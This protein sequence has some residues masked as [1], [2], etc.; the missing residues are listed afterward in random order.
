MGKR[1]TARTEAMKV[2]VTGG[3]G[4]VGK[5]V[6]RQ[7]VARGWSVRSFS[8]SRYDELASLGV[9]QRTGDIADSDAV[10]RAVEGCSCVVHTAA[11]AG[12]WGNAETFHRTNVLGT[13]HV[14][15]ACRHFS[16]RQLV[17]TS[18]PSVVHQGADIEGGDETLPYAT[19]PQSH[20][21]RTKIAAEKMVRAAEDLDTVSLRPHLIWGPGDPH[22][23]PRIRA[24]VR[25]GRIALPG[26]GQKL[27][28][29]TFI[30]NAASAH[31]AAIDTLISNPQSVR[32]RA[33]FITNGQPVE[34]AWIISEILRATGRQARVA[35]IPV[36]LAR[37]A[38]HLLEGAYRTFGIE[39]EPPLTRFVAHQLSSAHWYDLT[40]AQEL[41]GY[42]PEMS[43][44][45]GL[46]ILRKA[47]ASETE[48]KTPGAPRPA[49]PTL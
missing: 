47:W 12:V 40:S 31:L 37:L 32:G 3:G 42:R 6:V 48:E 1:E 21:Q 18:T 43:L 4:F 38:G 49:A 34:L 2:L 5:A 7:L 45:Q 11:I 25:A 46:E 14:L 27:V 22:L 44:E 26:G 16:V 23:V 41:L 24:R 19:E 30:E 15:E 28:D 13:A 9:E 33:F 20:Y 39:R 36:G 8:R 17:Y 29:T 35:S 10:Q